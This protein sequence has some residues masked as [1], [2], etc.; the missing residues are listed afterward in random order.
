MSRDNISI[1][2]QGSYVNFESSSEIYR[3]SL[4]LQGYLHITLVKIT[5]PNF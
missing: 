5:V 2:L 3:I 1:I 4:T